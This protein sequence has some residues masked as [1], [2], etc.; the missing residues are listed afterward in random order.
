MCTFAKASARHAANLSTVGCLLAVCAGTGCA[1]ATDM[2]DDNAGS[3]AKQRQIT[4]DASGGPGRW[5]SEVT[6]RATDHV[7]ETKTWWTY[8]IL[9]F[10][11]DATSVRVNVS[12]GSRTWIRSLEIDKTDRSRPHRFKRVFYYEGV[13]SIPVEYRNIW[14][15]Y[16]RAENQIVYEH[17]VAKD[18]WAK[19]VAYNCDLF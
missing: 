8:G 17:E 7:H 9:P 14:M 18:A 13:R 19:A 4:L 6:C 3:E 15:E 1:A 10:K 12:N 11:K 2:S 16:K 5:L